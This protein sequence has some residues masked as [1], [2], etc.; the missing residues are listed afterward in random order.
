MNEINKTISLGYEVS[1]RGR[2]ETLDFQWKIHEALYMK[3]L[4]PDIY[5]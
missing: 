1:S 4:E 3:E 5:V 2:S